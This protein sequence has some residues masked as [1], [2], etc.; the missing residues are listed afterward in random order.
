MVPV[1]HSKVILTFPTQKLRK[2]Q[3]LPQTEGSSELPP[4]SS[5]SPPG[6]PPTLCPLCPGEG[7]PGTR[8]FILNNGVFFPLSWQRLYQ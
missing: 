6:I 1:I 8:G 5:L 7:P 4:T 2:A 3:H